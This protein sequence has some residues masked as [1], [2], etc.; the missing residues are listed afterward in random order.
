[1]RMPGK[2]TVPLLLALVVVASVVAACASAPAPA[3]T[4]APAKPAAA[5][6]TK[7]PAAATAAPAVQPTA[8]AA[9]AQLTELRVGWA[10][11]PHMALQGVALQKG[12]FKEA[13]LDVKLTAFDT[14]APLFEAM[15]AGKLD[16]GMTGSTPTISTSAAKAPAIYFVG[17]HAESTDIFTVVGRKSLASPADI[18]GKK[19]LTAKGSVNHYF[20]DLMLNKFDLTEKDITLIHMDMADA[21]TAFVGN[22][23][24]F[25]SIGTAFW[26]QI[27]SK[28]SD[29][30]TLFTGDMLAK[31]PGKA[32]NTKMIEVT[33]ASQSFADKNPQAVT[34]YLDV[35]YNRTHKYFND[36]ATKA[37]ARQELLAWLKTTVNFNQSQDDLNKILDPVKYYTAAEQMKLFQ[38]GT[39]KASIEAQTQY[40]VDNNNL[41]AFQP[42]D[43]WANSKFLQAAAK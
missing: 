35:L 33:T 34:K 29:A 28:S 2:R 32:M 7:A 8:A 25:A 21:V 26:P 9:P 3:P 41:K 12:W 36:P 31:A 23:G 16:M 14:G 4:S 10:I 22:Q 20:L 5:E 43:A 27:L 15:A 17:S 18:K 13:G 39:Y 40:L 19:G 30:K 42:F 11:A 1:M 24:D 38:D 37:Q 6:P